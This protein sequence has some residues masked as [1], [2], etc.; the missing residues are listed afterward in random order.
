MPGPQ[1]A[2]GIAGGINLGANA[3]QQGA[4]QGLGPNVA[5]WAKGGIH[6]RQLDLIHQLRG[7]GKGAIPAG[8]MAKGGG[9]GKGK[10]KGAFGGG[11]IPGP[12]VPVAPMPPAQPQAGKGMGKNAMPPQGGFNPQ[13][14]QGGGFNPQPKQGAGPAAGQ[15]GNRGVQ[16]KGGIG[17]PLPQPK[18]GMKVA[19][20]LPNQPMLL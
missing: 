16:P 2:G 10:G 3:I 11:A 7:Q 19:P 12:P 18:G 4:K 8:G 5:G 14:K 13:P 1:G 15:V 9:K 20:M 17:G 6:G